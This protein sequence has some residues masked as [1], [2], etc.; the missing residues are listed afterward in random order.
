MN[1]NSDALWIEDEVL[2]KLDC[3]HNVQFYEVEE[4]CDNEERV[5]R[6]GRAEGLY[7]VYS[8]TA[9]G[10][11]LFIVLARA[12][13]NLWNV[14]TARTMDPSDQRKYRQRRGIR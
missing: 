4:A 14:V 6:R 11:Y 3:K 9:A 8:R 1:F 5:I 10:R 12:G 7:E 2:E 13:D